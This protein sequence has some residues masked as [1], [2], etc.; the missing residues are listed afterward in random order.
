MH[1]I[2]LNPCFQQED[3]HI[4]WTIYLYVFQITVYYPYKKMP[5]NQCFYIW[6]D[7]FHQSFY[8]WND[9]IQSLFF[10]IEKDVFQ[11]LFLQRKI[12]LPVN[13]LY[14]KGCLPIN[15]S[16]IAKDF[17]QSMLLP[18]ER[19]LPINIFLHSERCLLINAFT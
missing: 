14:I 8:I 17:F 12:W 4:I 13:V 1:I 16:Y 6:K 5:S 7:G 15:A 3:T 2:F 9:A 11:S 19:W 10:C 18:R